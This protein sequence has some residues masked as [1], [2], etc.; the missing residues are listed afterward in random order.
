M[1]GGADRPYSVCKRLVDG[2]GSKSRRRR[3]RRREAPVIFCN[4]GPHPCFTRLHANIV[5]EDGAFT[6][7]VRIFNHLK[8]EE[9]AWGQEIAAT[10]DMA[11]LMV[12][13]LAEQFS[14]PQ[15]CI[16][17]KIVTWCYRDGTIH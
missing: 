11:S 7:S 8:T 17:I 4:K 14:I 13:S 3:R 10:F 5:E 12:G 6:V 15:N 2:R 9:A 1:S 16:S